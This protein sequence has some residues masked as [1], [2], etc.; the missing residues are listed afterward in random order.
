MEEE[1][2]D[3]TD[4]NENSQSCSPDSEAEEDKRLDHTSLTD[5]ILLQYTSGSTGEL[6]LL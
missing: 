4:P 5:A 2:E 1:R 3:N 6:S